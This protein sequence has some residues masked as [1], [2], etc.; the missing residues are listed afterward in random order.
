MD[1]FQTI[2]QIVDESI[3]SSSYIS[4]LISSGVFITYTLINKLIELFKDKSRNKPLVEMAE[5]L[6]E[7]TANVVKLNSVLDKTLNDAEKK[8]TAKAKGIIPIVFNTF[9][10][11]VTRSCVDMIIN[12]HIETNKDLINENV[13]KLVTTEYYKVHAVLSTYEVNGSNLATKL[14][15]EWIA[16]TIDDIVSIMYNG[17]NAITRISQLNNKLNMNAS[18]YAI[19]IDNKTFNT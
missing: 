16:E 15:K 1:E 14:E 13:N 19:Y 3:R 4:V 10:N 2:N 6:R 5:G 17:Q 12:N 9:C 18:S 11:A 7:V 8:E